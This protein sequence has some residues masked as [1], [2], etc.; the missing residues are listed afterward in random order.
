VLKEAAC[1]Y[2]VDLN[3]TKL[4]SPSTG[5]YSIPSIRSAN[6][7]FNR[8]NVRVSLSS[9]TPGVLSLSNLNSHPLHPATVHFPIAFLSLSY[10]LDIVYALSTLPATAGIVRSL[11]NIAPLLGEISRFSHYLNIIGIITAV[12]AVLT[13]GQQLLG[14]IKRQDLAT[15][16]QKSKNKSATVQKMHPKMKVAFLHAALNDVAVFGSVY[17]WWSRR[18]VVGYA[19]SD[20]NVLLSVNMLVALLASA[21]LGGLMVYEYGVGVTRQGEKSLR[22]NDKKVE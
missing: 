6:T 13:G 2:F 16:V 3:H 11:Y 19:P 18:N 10:G 4:H 9:F 8:K 1:F 14:M 12:P 15:K 21:W 5:T 20:T 7:I 17:N 22:E